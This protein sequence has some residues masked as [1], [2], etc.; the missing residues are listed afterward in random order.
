M[1]NHVSNIRLEFVGKNTDQTVELH[2]ARDITHVIVFH[3]EGVMVISG[4]QAKNQHINGI[5]RTFPEA[6]LVVWLLL[7]SFCGEPY[8]CVLISAF[9]TIKDYSPSPPSALF[10]HS[11][12]FSRRIVWGGGGGGW[13]GGG[14]ASF[15][16]WTHS[17]IW[18]PKMLTYS[19]DFL[20]LFIVGN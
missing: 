9:D 15:E 12:P 1:S 11:Q 5:F 13:G 7:T 19:F 17:Y 3:N 6:L 2:F 18:S 10:C 8:Q 4:R 14:G 16:K 20:Y